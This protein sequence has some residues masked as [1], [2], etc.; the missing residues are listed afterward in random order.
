MC[1]CILLLATATLSPKI[2]K[3]VKYRRIDIVE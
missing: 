3:R 1:T 2:V